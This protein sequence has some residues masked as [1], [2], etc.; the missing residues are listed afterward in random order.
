[1]DY[2]K[3]QTK[4]INSIAEAEETISKEKLGLF[5]QQLRI[6]QGLSRKE[7]AEKAQV[8]RNIIGYWENGKCCISIENADRM[9]KALSGQVVIGKKNI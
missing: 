3:N 9:L 1:M 8:S 4:Q 6:K 5:F 2:I 7:L